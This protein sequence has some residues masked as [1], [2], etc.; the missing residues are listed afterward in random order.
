MKNKINPINAGLLFGL[1]LGLFHL[2]WMVLVYAKY[3]QKVLDF[4]FWVHFIKPV[5]EVESFDA[6]RGIILLALTVSC[7]FVFGYLM[8]RSFNALNTNEIEIQ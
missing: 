2:L 4:I 5:F 6:S 3:G 1:F 7:G 8:A